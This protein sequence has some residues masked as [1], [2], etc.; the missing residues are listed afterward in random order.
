MEEDNIHHR[1][2]KLREVAVGSRQSVTVNS[3]LSNCSYDSAVDSLV[4]LFAECSQNPLA[5][6]K[7]I[8]RFLKKCADPHSMPV[9][10]VPLTAPNKWVYT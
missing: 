7:N 8:A 3:A 5:K 1:L 6:D 10:V 9:A 4:A 2:L